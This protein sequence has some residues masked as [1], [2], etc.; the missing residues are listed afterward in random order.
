MKS[1]VRRS[2]IGTVAALHLFTAT[3]TRVFKTGLA[4]DRSGLVAVANETVLP[5]W[6]VCFEHD[7]I[8]E[9]SDPA[10]VVQFV[11]VGNQ[12]VGVVVAVHDVDVTELV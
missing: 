12:R 1:V 8:K 4:L 2:T 5:V 3:D 6:V 7:I 9:S 11:E 10:P